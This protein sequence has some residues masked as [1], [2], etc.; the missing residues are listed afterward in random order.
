MNWPEMLDSPS[1]PCRS[2]CH[3]CPCWTILILS[4]SS[5]ER[6]I[7]QT[8][9]VF[10]RGISSLAWSHLLSPQPPSLFPPAFPGLF[11]AQPQLPSAPQGFAH[12][13]ALAEGAA[14]TNHGDTT[15]PSLLAQ[16]SPP[17]PTRTQGEKAL[18]PDW[19]P[20]QAQGPKLAGAEVA[21]ATLV[22]AGAMGNSQL[23]SGC[24]DDSCSSQGRNAALFKLLA[25]PHYLIFL[26]KNKN[27]YL[28]LDNYCPYL[29][30]SLP[31]SLGALWRPE[32]CL[33]A[34]AVAQSGV[35]SPML[36]RNVGKTTHLP[37]TIP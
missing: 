4:L 11:P 33:L 14:M 22:P 19:F 24:C 3:D 13:N 34:E 20:D 5:T 31:P 37:G 1:T 10:P 2:H 16:Q 23:I 35:I 29:V 9:D 26:K 8:S 12:S 36:C 32:R 18:Q 17:F 28:W 15:P 21:K 6:E 30:L 7:G 25:L 27:Q